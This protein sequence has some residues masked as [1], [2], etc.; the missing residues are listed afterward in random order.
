MFVDRNRLNG[1]FAPPAAVLAFRW[2]S[3]GRDQGPLRL[4]FLP[5][6]QCTANALQSG[7]AQHV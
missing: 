5:V 2:S 1:L 3:G 7:E 4:G 6:P